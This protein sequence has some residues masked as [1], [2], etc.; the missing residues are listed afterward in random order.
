MGQKSSFFSIFC[1]LPGVC[2]V[3]NTPHMKYEDRFS[4]NLVCEHIVAFIME[5]TFL[6][7]LGV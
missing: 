3:S 7:V 4:S 6:W 5:L 2:C 1:H